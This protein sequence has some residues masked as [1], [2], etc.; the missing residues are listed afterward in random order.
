MESAGPAWF[1]IFLAGIVVIAGIAAAL[2]APTFVIP[3]TDLTL[4]FKTDGVLPSTKLRLL[5]ACLTIAVFSLSAMFWLTVNVLTAD[6]KS[7]LA[8]GHATGLAPVLEDNKAGTD[9]LACAVQYYESQGFHFAED[10]SSLAGEPVKLMT[11]F[12]QDNNNVWRA[13]GALIYP[14]GA[15]TK[16][17]VAVVHDDGAWKKGGAI[18]VHRDGL[19]SSLHI[20][21]LL[22]RHHLQELAAQHDYLLTLGLASNSDGEDLPENIKLAFARAHNLGVAARKLKW[23]AFDR[24]WPLSLGYAKAIAE[25]EGEQKRQ[26]PLILIGVIANRNVA[27][28]DVTYAAMQTVPIS[29]VNLDG[30]SNAIKEPRDS[31]AITDTSEYVTASE[32]FLVQKD[33]YVA[34]ILPAVSGKSD[35]LPNC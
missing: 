2:I 32:I 10:F 26:R 17:E 5:A 25:S 30:Y 1:F 19:N 12:E 8:L 4:L 6:Y 24:I 16:F 14:Q 29:L 34:K 33:S 27:V 28:P 3:G 20:E 31:H 13:M 21:R 15:S 9:K 22:K 23:A 18:K 7:K 35:D 11:K